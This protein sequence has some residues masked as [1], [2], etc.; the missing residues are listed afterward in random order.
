MIV[1]W[2]SRLYVLH[3]SVVSSFQVN[4]NRRGN[5]LEMFDAHTCTYNSCS[6]AEFTSE[7]ITF[8]QFMCEHTNC[9]QITC[10]QF[11]SLWTGE[12]WTII[13][14]LWWE[15]PAFRAADVRAWVICVSSTPVSRSYVEYYLYSEKLTSRFI[16][17]CTS[18][19]N[20]HYCLCLRCLPTW[21]SAV[22]WSK[23]L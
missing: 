5:S 23:P 3:V 20:C 4:N 2:N 15:S 1:P 10:E 21:T 7:Q 19:S 11:V 12:V 16:Y 14:Y 18:N 22:R 9:E 6:C 17:S 13:S 8:E